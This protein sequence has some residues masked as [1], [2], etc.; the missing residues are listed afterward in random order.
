MNWLYQLN[1]EKFLLF[2]LV[3]T[4]VSGLTMT[5]PIYGTK[6]VPI[7]IRA[8]LAVALALLIAPTQWHVAVAYPGTIVNYLVFLG[9]EL[10]IGVCLG[11]GIVI[12]FS[13]IQL[14]GQMIGRV[15][16]LL[17]ADVFDPTSG[18]SVPTFSQVLFLVALAVF[19]CI[20]GHRMVMAGLLDTFQGIPPGSFTPWDVPAFQT[21]S[22]STGPLHGSIAGTLVLLLQQSFE[23]GIRASVP[24]VTAVLLSILVL[25]LIGRT[26]PQFNILMVGFGFNS[27][28]ALALMSLTLGASVWAFQEQI[29]PT[30]QTLFDALHAYL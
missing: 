21:V 1:L 11:L 8:L 19:V 26:M 28:L 23:L 2:T 30:L 13:G 4:R 18:E 3:L 7:R 9:S 24:V 27:M 14:A 20:G 25:G 5:A 12:L 15:S 17:L 10:M 6:D 16:G 29:E 22:G